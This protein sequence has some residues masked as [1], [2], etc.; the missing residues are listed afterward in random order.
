M[1]SHCA[2]RAGSSGSRRAGHDGDA[3]CRPA[4]ICIQSRECSPQLLERLT[5]ATLFPERFLGSA[6]VNTV[7]RSGGHLL[8]VTAPPVADADQQVDYYL[9]L[10]PERPERGAERARI[11]LVGLDDRSPRWLSEKI[12]DPGS[13]DAARVRAVLRAF[14]EREEGNGR[15]VGLSY[16]EPSEPLERLGRDLGVPGDQAHSSC[17][18]LGTKHAGRELLRSAGV[19]VPQGSALCHTLTELA[20]EMAHLVRRGCRRFVVKLNSTAYGGGL[21]NALLDLGDIG[22]LVPA[23]DGQDG[24]DDGR[25]ADRILARLPDAVLMDVKITW[26]DFAEAVEREGALAEELL[27]ADE[28]LSPSFQ[29]RIGDDGT[30]AAVSTHDQVLSGSGQTFT[31]CAFPADAAYRRAVIGHG[32]RVGR[33]LRERGVTG[34]DY[35]VDFLALRS[36]AGWRLVGCEL[37]LRATG[38][39]HAFTMAGGLLGVAP[40]EDGRLIV[41]GAERVYEAS[42]GIMDTRYRGLRPARLIRAISGSPLRYDHVSRTGVV[43]HMLSAVVTYGKFGAVCIGRNGAEAGAMM[44]GVRALVDGLVAAGP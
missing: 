17:I 41:D 40:T 2:S 36:A 30:V 25:L 9:G 13:A 23:A 16:F 8:Y 24:Q 28:L 12:L 34:G 4:R 5:G 21:G 15:C 38:T 1:C 42:D 7:C 19:E 35:G 10:L 31:G 39:K 32:L 22:D 29:G 37:N 11:R 14:V 33:A 18:P 20:G 26:Q 27:A 43:L 6:V 3:S 44:R